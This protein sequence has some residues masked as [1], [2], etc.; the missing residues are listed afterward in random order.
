MER[1]QGLSREL[2]EFFE[3]GLKELEEFLAKHAAFYN[4]LVEN[5]PEGVIEE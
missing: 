3:Q 4:W 5:E 1:L 2:I